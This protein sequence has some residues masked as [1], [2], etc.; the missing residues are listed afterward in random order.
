MFKHAKYKQKL[1]QF[2]LWTREERKAQG[3][4]RKN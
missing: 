4:D 2:G 3:K 1:K